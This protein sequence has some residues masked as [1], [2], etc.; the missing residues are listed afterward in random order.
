M[1]F[2]RIEISAFRIY[3]NPEDAT[4]DFTT[5]N[6]EVADFVSLYAPNGFG[7]TSFYDAVEWGI[8]NNIQRFWQNLSVAE[9]SIDALKEVATGQVKL[10]RHTDSENDTY[11]QIEDDKSEIVK[12][13]LH[14]DGRSTIDAKK[15]GIVNKDFRKVVLSQEWISAFLKEINGEQRYKIF[16]ENPDLRDLDNYYKGLK[17]LVS[18][19][20]ERT[21]ILDRKIEASKAEIVDIAES[22][23]LDTIN[24]TISV[25]INY[26]EGLSLISL[27]MSQEQVLSF[28][29]TI[30]SRLVSN[31]SNSFLQIIDNVTLAK[32]GSEDLI[33]TERYYEFPAIKEK[34]A[35]EIRAYN[36]LINQFEQLTA[37][38]NERDNNLKDR[39]AYQ[40]RIDQIDKVLTNFPEFNRIVKVLSTKREQ[41]LAIDNAI[42]DL[43]QNLEDEKR[44][45]VQQEAEISSLFKQTEELQTRILRIPVV[46]LEIENAE[47]NLGL[48]R[49]Q[50]GVLTNE[51]N[52]HDN[53][54]VVRQ[55]KIDGYKNTLTLILKD[56]IPII[57]IDFLGENADIPEKLASNYKRLSEI[58][59]QLDLV[60]WQIDQNQSL[61]S[62]LQDFIKK[63]LEIVNDTQISSCPLCNQ[64]YA[65][66]QELTQKISGNTAL[67]EGLQLLFSQ[68]SELSSIS[69][70]TSDQITADKRILSNL[71]ENLIV[72]EGA[73]IAGINV[74]KEGL[75]SRIKELDKEMEILEKKISAGREELGGVLPDNLVG[76]LNILLGDKTSELAALR[77]KLSILKLSISGKEKE[78]Q[79]ETGKVDLLKTEITSLEKNE[80]YAIVTGWF[81]KELPGVNISE[82]PILDEKGGLVTDLAKALEKFNQLELDIAALQTALSSYSNDEIKRLHDVTQQLINRMDS[83]I[84]KFQEFLKNNFGIVSVPGLKDD[85]VKLLDDKVDE[86][87][88]GIDRADK[89][90]IEFE[91]LERY[92][93]NL[94][95]YL[96]SENLKTEIIKSEVEKEY[97]TNEVQVLLENERDKTKAYLENKVKDFFYINLI[98]SIYNKIDPHPNFK[99]V[100]FRVNFDSDNPRL[101]IYVIDATSEELLIPNLYFSTAQINILSLSIFLASAL[102]S[103]TYNCIFIDDPIQSL[104]SINILSTIDLIR[105]IVV[106]QKRQI[107]LSTHD[108]NFHNLL[109]KKMPSNLFKSKFIEL[110]TFGKV[111]RQ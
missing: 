78:T 35:I 71:Y 21:E 44:L 92:A 80:K 25:L 23:L 53:N 95:P 20:K 17:S 6:G 10:W 57:S 94:S 50:K 29:N 42:K 82:S 70:N 79:I 28:K 100:D 32:F 110:E 105:S 68:K 88:K 24:S 69:S 43:R 90:R 102:N 37:L 83:G 81:L 58:K 19:C 11:V 97:L 75:I 22:N 46:K 51:N 16:M 7:K 12:R 40:S 41:M 98:N 65:S 49:N 64:N 27:E 1:K 14:M 91:K 104:D 109:K 77:N 15:E 48:L 108:E 39:S 8:T 60:N 76:Q 33:G 59:S 38:I 9:K 47:E 72:V 5:E 107:V 2:K 45:E 18:V 96:Q 52:L 101:D 111:K 61:N 85:L 74:I 26:G 86:A 31:K 4:F 56:E 106:N 36:D 89:I 93:Q 84:L 34:A 87:R 103:N 62:T 63:G 66:Y 73:A 3:D 13:E 55:S 30:S 54:I 67:N 99:S